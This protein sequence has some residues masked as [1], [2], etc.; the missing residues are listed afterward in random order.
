M[1]WKSWDHFIFICSKSIFQWKKFIQNEWKISFHFFISPIFLFYDGA[2]RR[3][4]PI[5]ILSEIF[6]LFEYFFQF[7]KQLLEGGFSWVYFCNNKRNFNDLDILQVTG[8][9]LFVG[10]K[11]NINWFFS[12]TTFVIDCDDN[13]GGVILLDTADLYL[14]KFE[15]LRCPS[16]L[17]PLTWFISLVIKN[18]FSEKH[19]NSSQFPQPCTFITLPI[20]NVTQFDILPPPLN[21]LEATDEIHINFKSIPSELR[22]ICNVNSCIHKT[23]NTT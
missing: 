17:K 23:W 15:L 12:Y 3:L 1:S 18:Y 5:K 6:H 8:N 22:K 4:H 2:T 20:Q 21:I 7:I 10:F 14:I 19:P 16:T 11:P 13:F 9:L